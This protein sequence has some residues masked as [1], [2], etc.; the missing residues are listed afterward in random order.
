MMFV[1]HF[2]GYIQTW[3]D[4]KRPKLPLALGCRCTW[5]DKETGEDLGQLSNEQRPTN[6]SAKLISRIPKD[7]TNKRDILIL[8]TRFGASNP[9][10]SKKI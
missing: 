10:I 7:L 1:S 2:T 9:A 4:P 3:K 6:P 8:L 5:I